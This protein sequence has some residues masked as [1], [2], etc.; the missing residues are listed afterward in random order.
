MKECIV[1][2]LSTGGSGG[3]DK[4][5]ENVTLNFG[6]VTY[7]YFLQDAKGGTSSAGDF[8]WLIAE[9]AEG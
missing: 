3:E 4:L 7:S 5:T 9:N 1:T 8:K 6:E 2:N